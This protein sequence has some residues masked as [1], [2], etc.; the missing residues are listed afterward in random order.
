MKNQIIK[1]VAGF[2]VAEVFYMDGEIEMYS[3]PISRFYSTRTE[4]L[5]DQ[6]RIYRGCVKSKVI[7]EKD[8]PIPDLIS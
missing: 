8:L 4:L 6:R 2:Y 5:K 1:S 7:N 3:D